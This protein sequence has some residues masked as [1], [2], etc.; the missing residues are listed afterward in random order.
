MR[1]KL[2]RLMQGYSK[3]FVTTIKKYRNIWLQ[4]FISILVFNND[5]ICQNSN[6]IIFIVKINNIK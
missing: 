1:E 3:V 5:E 6:R 4:F 2:R